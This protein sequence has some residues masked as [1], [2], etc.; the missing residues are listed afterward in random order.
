VPGHHHHGSRDGEQ[1][2]Y[3]G[4]E[5][6]P[7]SDLDFLEARYYSGEK[8]RVLSQDPVFNGLPK[9]HNLIN[10]QSLNSYN[11]AEGNPIIKK[12]PT[13]SAAFGAHPS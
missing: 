13:G 7:D 4:K 11:Y 8:G 10:P 9:Q 5:Y 1:R 12:D 2:Q 6:D 3:I